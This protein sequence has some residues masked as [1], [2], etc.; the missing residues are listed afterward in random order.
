MRLCAFTLTSSRA[1][2]SQSKLTIMQTFMFLIIINVLDHE[3]RESVAVHHRPLLRCQKAFQLELKC[4]DSTLISVLPEQLPKTLA[5]VLKKTNNPNTFSKN[6]MGEFP[7]TQRVNAKKYFTCASSIKA[8]FLPRNFENS[9]IIST[10]VV[11]LA[12]SECAQACVERA[13]THESRHTPER[14]RTSAKRGEKDTKR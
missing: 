10:F 6:L 2:N 4:L 11:A 9:T 14:A 5:K 12:R 13:G 3:V 8:S 1:S 7:D